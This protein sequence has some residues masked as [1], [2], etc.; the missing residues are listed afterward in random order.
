M[1]PEDKYLTPPERDETLHEI[2]EGEVWVPPLIPHTPTLHISAANYY[3]HRWLTMDYSCCTKDRKPVGVQTDP[4]LVELPPSSLE[5]LSSDLVLTPSE[6][7]SPI[8]IPP[9]IVAHSNHLQTALDLS[10]S[11]Q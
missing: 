3:D 1:D 2:M 6:N 10:V 11:K 4:E 9:P 7:S 8:P 5:G